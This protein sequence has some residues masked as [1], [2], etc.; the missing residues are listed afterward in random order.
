VIATSE[1]RIDMRGIFISKHLALALAL[2]LLP[3]AA[4]AKNCLKV[5]DENSPA[6]TVSGRITT[7]HR[8]PKAWSDVRAAKGFFLKLDT[9]L[10]TGDTEVCLK[11]DKIAII[12]SDD[13]Q[14]RKWVNRHVTI[15]GK[16][17]RFVS[18]LVNP[19]IFIRPGQIV[20]Q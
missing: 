4:N 5:D 17:G 2:L 15:E 11:W 14:L 6:A 9:P 20:R 13:S 7:H 18:A 3:T 1:L 16:L 10:L 12:P 8:V 19:A